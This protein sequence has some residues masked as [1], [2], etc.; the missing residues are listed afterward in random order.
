MNI[1]NSHF[2]AGGKSLDCLID[3]SN[4]NIGYLQISD[5]NISGTFKANSGRFK[6]FNV[7]GDKTT[8]EELLCHDCAVEQSMLLAGRFTARVQLTGAEVKG[9]LAFSEYSTTARKNPDGV[10]ELVS[11]NSHARWASGAKLDLSEFRT[12]AIAANA[13]DLVIE[14]DGDKLRDEKAPA[15]GHSCERRDMEPK[16]VPT[17]LTGA[18][19]RTIVPGRSFAANENLK[20]QRQH[21]SDAC[22][23]G[24]LLELEPHDLVR[25]VRSAHTISYDP[26]PYEELAAALTRAGKTHEAVEVRIASGNKRTETEKNPLMKGWRWI[27]YYVSSYGHENWWAL[28]WFV[29]LIGVGTFAHVRASHRTAAEPHQLEAFGLRILYSMWFAIDRAVPPLHLYPHLGE[30]GNFRWPYR[31][32]FYL[33]RVV[34]TVLVTVFAYGIIGFAH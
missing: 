2:E 12:D 14:T 18:R 22:F 15:A 10:V 6:T 16:F 7:V 34:G 17:T 1:H 20:E 30:E 24:A 3:L 4:A 5:T 21:S 26:R 32:Y 27:Y 31:H 13:L 29:G 28:V 19:Y 33:H 8:I 11:T 9:T 23:A 25:L